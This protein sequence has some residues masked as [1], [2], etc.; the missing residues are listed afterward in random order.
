MTAVAGFLLASRGDVDFVLFAAAIAG[1]TLVIASACVINNYFDR[2]ID[3]I[4]TRTK[5]RP[6]VA[7]LVSGRDAVIFGILLGVIGTVILALFTNWIVVII[8]LV[9]F[10]DY[11]FLYGMWTKR[12]SIHGTLVGSISGAAP[13]LAGYVAASG[14]ID[15]GALIVFA[16]LFFW[17]MP[18]FYSIAIYR[19]K[20]YKAA[21]VPVITVV[22][23]VSYT[24]KQIFAYTL[25]FTVACISLFIFEYAGYTY[26]L[27]MSL[28]CGYW[29]W[30]ALRGLRTAK[31]DIWSRSM[32]RFS[33]ITLLSFCFLI[34][35]DNFVP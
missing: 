5:T 35:I 3:S 8:G 9:G 27:A 6:L 30:L 11:V 7:G 28:L 19:R 15:L 24:K 4:M 12:Q 32:F 21:K 34:S 16:V 25:L 14:Q 13:I 29:L 23:G 20:E 18:E 2:D 1:T 22:K 31:N 17:Q 33:L 26:L 10:V